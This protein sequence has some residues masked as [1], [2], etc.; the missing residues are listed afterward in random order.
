MP[1]RHREC[2]RQARPGRGGGSGLTRCRTLARPDAAACLGPMTWA[3][4][5]S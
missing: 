4:P 5:C 1:P 2:Q 3:W